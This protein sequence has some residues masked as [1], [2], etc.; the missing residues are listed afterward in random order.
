MC[1]QEVLEET[2]LK[3]LLKRYT[4]VGQTVLILA[5]LENMITIEPVGVMKMEIMRIM[6]YRTLAANMETIPKKNVTSLGIIQ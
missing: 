6:I 3:M 4:N 1:M 5:L 2:V